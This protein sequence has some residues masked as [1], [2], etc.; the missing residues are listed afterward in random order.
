MQF[1]YDALLLPIRGILGHI[2]VDDISFKVYQGQTL[3]LVGESGCGKTTTG[4][5]ILRLVEPT[6]GQVIYEGIDVA[7]LSA[8]DLR[9]M[10]RRLQIIFQDPYGSL[11]PRMTIESALVEPMRIHGI[12]TSKNDRIARAAALLE[13]VDLPAAHLRRCKAPR[14]RSSRR[15]G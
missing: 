8:Y 6:G 10:R 9:Q 14:P 15:A 13:E 3:G 2:A 5:A 4:R 12:G 7:S 11:N 1:A